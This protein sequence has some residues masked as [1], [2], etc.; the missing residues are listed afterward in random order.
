[1]NYSLFIDDLRELSYLGN[2][3]PEEWKIARTSFEAIKI[4]SEIGIPD[5]I[6]FDHD[7]GGDDT[8]MVFVKWWS[9]NIEKQFPPFII[10]SS[11]PVG[12]LN[13]ESFMN[14]YNRSLGE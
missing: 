4:V 7:L 1:M 13:L 9:N 10:H 3:N 8:S 6:A 2:V 14:S 11:N 12:K 5:F